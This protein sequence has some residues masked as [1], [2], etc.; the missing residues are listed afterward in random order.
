[1]S[2]LETTTNVWV[3]EAKVE[4]LSSALHAQTEAVR[5]IARTLREWAVAAG[6]H[7]PSAII[8]SKLLALV[9]DE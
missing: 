9:G 7:T 8:A 2:D 3:L 4:A 5:A 6:G 1:M